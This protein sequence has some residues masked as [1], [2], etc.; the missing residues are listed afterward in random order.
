MISSIDQNGIFNLYV[1]TEDKSG[2]VTNVMGGAFMPS[3]SSDGRILYS[4]YD[5]ATYHI[6]IIDSAVIIRDSKVGYNELE[7]EYQKYDNKISGEINIESE[8]YSTQMT[9]ISFMPK[10]L[11]DYKTIKPGLYCSSYD[12]LNFLPVILFT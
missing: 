3:V 8:E 12:L 5:N 2:Y 6:A 1:D 4:L 10:V 7:F 11:W 9:K